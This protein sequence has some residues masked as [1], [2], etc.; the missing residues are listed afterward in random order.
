MRIIGGDFG[1]RRIKTPNNLLVRPT[2]DMAKEA[3]FNVLAHR[4][5]LEMTEV[6][7]LFAGT[8]NISYEFASRGAT[9][10]LSVEMNSRNADFIRQTANSFGMRNLQVI[11]ANALLFL[12]RDKHRYDIIFADPPYDLPEAG[13]IPGL[14]LTRGLLAE[15][16]LL[17]ME[18]SDA[19][20][21]SNVQGFVELRKYGR[22][23]FSIFRY[24]E[25]QA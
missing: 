23:R 19:H 13:T 17:I 22:V 3:L 2:T 11:R 14:I 18:H 6:L 1:G 24:S 25:P 5:E 4:M 21:F 15:E 10:V 20:D 12:S 9:R 7:D 8:G 16:G